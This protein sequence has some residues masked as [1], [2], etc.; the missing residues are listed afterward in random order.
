MYEVMRYWDSNDPEWSAEQ[1]EFAAGW[2]R[3]PKWVVSRSLRSV[4][5]NVTLV[6]DD[7][8]AV[9]RGLKA[10]LDGEI[11]VSGPDLARSLVT[12]TFSTPCATRSCRLLDL[13]TSGGTS[14]LCA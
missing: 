13:R 4:G 1:R 9:V 11:A 14:V 5:P 2:R 10:R 6:E 8:E 12:G 7:V 3:Q